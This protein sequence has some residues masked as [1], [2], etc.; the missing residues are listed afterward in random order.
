MVQMHRYMYE[1][2][3][4]KIPKGMCVCHKCD[5]PACNNPDHLFLGTWA[6]NNKDMANK[7]RQAKGNRINTAVLTEDQVKE[8]YLASG[9]QRTLAKIYGV[10]QT[11]IHYIKCRKS[12][13]HL[14]N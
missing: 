14:R 4:G 1:K 6:D 5:N 13:K 8:I 10:S 9:S 7:E 11:A 3:I 2:H 12:W